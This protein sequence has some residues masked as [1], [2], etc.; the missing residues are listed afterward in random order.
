MRFN[1]AEAH[2]L[3][4]GK[5]SRT[6]ESLPGF[7]SS[8]RSPPPSG[9]F[10]SVVDLSRSGDSVRDLK[11]REGPAWAI[12]EDTTEH[13]E[14]A[15]I[16]RHTTETLPWELY[17][18]A[19][20]RGAKDRLRPD[21]LGNYAPSVQKTL[22]AIGKPVEAI[23]YLDLTAYRDNW[24]DEWEDRWN[25]PLKKAT[26]NNWIS[27]FRHFYAFL[28][29]KLDLPIRNVAAKLERPRQD[30]LDRQ[31]RTHEI[32]LP[33]TFDAIVEEAFRQQDYGWAIC[34]RFLWQTAGRITDAYYLRWQDLDLERGR[35]VIRRPKRGGPKPKLL[36]EDLCDDFRSLRAL[37]RAEAGDAVFR[38][39][40]H[41]PWERED[42]RGPKATFRLWFTR[43]FRKHAKGAGCKQYVHPHLIRASAATAL[44]R[45]GVPE[46]A[47]RLQGDW[48]SSRALR[49]YLHDVVEDHRDRLRGVL[50]R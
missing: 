9:R 47:I 17:Y 20:V 35:V 44:S 46:Q 2:T 4:T 7:S 10:Y 48:K 19:W 22:A 16:D 43:H 13:D 32:L 45:A 1:P 36:F 34:A 26:T 27:A 3:T 41:R 5:A 39:D 50:D 18:D 25:R 24:R 28:V 14:R 15:G 42:H 38:P 12:A 29:D 30:D 33:E 37:E 8:S 23:T 21:T 49:P 6:T 11:Q 31:R 40:L